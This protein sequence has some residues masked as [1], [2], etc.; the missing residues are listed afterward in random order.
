[1]PPLL[2]CGSFGA[3]KTRTLG[4]A[5][6]RLRMRNGKTRVLVCTHAN[7]AADLYITKVLHD[8]DGV[9]Q[10]GEGP[11]RVLRIYYERRK[12]ASIPMYTEMIQHYC[13]PIDERGFFKTV[14]KEDIEQA[15]VGYKTSFEC[16]QIDK[17]NY[18]LHMSCK[19]LS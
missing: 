11:K 8:V 19:Q 5:L 4:Q 12:I 13:L 7:S 17:I 16:V 14:T 15:E 18:V 9:K 6:L 2:I 10:T 1:M 3:G